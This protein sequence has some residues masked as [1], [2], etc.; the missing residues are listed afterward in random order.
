MWLF[1]FSFYIRI[2]EMVESSIGI[3]AGPLIAEES[4]VDPV[5]GLV[6]GIGFG[7]SKIVSKIRNKNKDDYTIDALTNE[8]EKKEP[9]RED[10]MSGWRDARS[11]DA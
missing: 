5:V 7:L 2:K 3:S 1:A 4:I 10:M 9:T 8:E 11:R 6:T